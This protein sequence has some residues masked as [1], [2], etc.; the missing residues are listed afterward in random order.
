M[1][2]EIDKPNEGDAIKVLSPNSKISIHRNS[3]YS[4]QSIYWED[5]NPLG[6]TNKQ[7]ADKIVELEVIYNKME[8][9][10]KR[11]VEYNRLN[12]LE[13]IGEDAINGTTLHADAI[14]AIKDK[15]PK[16]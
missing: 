10:R 15:Y 6:I 7:I 11:M 9:S 14:Q 2:R 3:D 12:Q 16:E 8:Y 4:I 13:M 5:G 1:T